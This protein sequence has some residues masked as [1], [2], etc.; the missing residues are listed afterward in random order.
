MSE[1]SVIELLEQL[2]DI[3]LVEKQALIDNDGKKISEIV[4]MKLELSN[5]L[6]NTKA[7]DLEEEIKERVIEIKELQE[8]NALL[9]EQA[10]SYT[11]TFLSSLQNAAQKSTT[12]SNEGKMETEKRIDI[13]D[14]SL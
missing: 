7:N 3:L 5:Q 2:K 12:Y 13:L 4:E 11:E 10:L 1:Q 6:E 9:T 14:Q 8:T